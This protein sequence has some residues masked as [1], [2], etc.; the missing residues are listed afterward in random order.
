[1]D[2]Y[3]SSLSTKYEYTSE[4][5]CIALHDWSIVCPDCLLI[6]CLCYLRVSPWFYDAVS[7]FRGKPRVL[8]C[9]HLAF[10]MSTITFAPSLARRA[11][12][13]H[14]HCKPSYM[15]S[16]SGSS[17]IMEVKTFSATQINQLQILLL[18]LKQL[19]MQVQNQIQPWHFFH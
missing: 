10:T 18:K 7:Q 1:M 4:V 2:V 14:N 15:G 3:G 16:N 13:V 6:Y 17:G 19:K 5:G 8:T 9:D 11:P 12:G